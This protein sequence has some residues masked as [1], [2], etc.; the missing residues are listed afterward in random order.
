ML[1]L[2]KFHEHPKS[3]ILN[4][5]IELRQGN[6]IILDYSNTVTKK[7]L[8]I[9]FV[10]LIRTT[11]Q[12]FRYCIIACHAIITKYY[13]TTYAVFQQQNFEFLSEVNIG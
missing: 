3:K 12:I 2:E 6:K 13:V 9:K 1:G 11:K 4:I 5:Y 7:E 8:P 10:V